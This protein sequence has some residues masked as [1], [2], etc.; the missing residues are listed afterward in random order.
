MPASTPCQQPQVEDQAGTL[1]SGLE[2]DVAAVVVGDRLADT[3]TKAGPLAL[4]LG[5]KE[6]L[7]NLL[8]IGLG[9]TRAVIL[10]RQRNR[11][12]R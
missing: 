1:V 9:N 12:L 3:Q 6:R 8:S 4:F 7:E 10:N 11:S 2:P 5:R